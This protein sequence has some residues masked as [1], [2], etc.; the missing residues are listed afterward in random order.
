[1]WL[2]LLLLCRVVEPTDGQ[3]EGGVDEGHH[4]VAVVFVLLVSLHGPH[5]VGITGQGGDSHLGYRKAVSEHPY[6]GSRASTTQ[7]IELLSIFFDKICSLN[8]IETF[9]LI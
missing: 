1:M 9:R 3:D 7:H 8:K 4:D 5:R 6:R 2:L